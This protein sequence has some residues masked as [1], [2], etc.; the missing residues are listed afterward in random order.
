[1]PSTADLVVL[2]SL[3]RGQPRTGSLQQRLEAFYRPQAERYDRFREH[4]LHGRAELL[5]RLDLRPGQVLVELGAGTARNAEFLGAALATLARYEAVDLCPALLEQAERRAARHPVIRV[6]QADAGCYRPPGPV[7]RVLFSYALTMMPAWREALDN[8]ITMLVSG[9]LL[10]VVDFHVAHAMAPAGRVRHSAFVRAVWPR[11][12]RRDGVELDAARLDAL[13]Q[14]LQRL[15][16]AERMGAL[17]FVPLL[18]VPHYLFI[19][20]KPGPRPYA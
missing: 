7:H 3:L 8:A 19:G 15:F 14:R 5:R 11:W 12:F 1:M 18:R 10:G 17:P 13:E 16:L 2:R 20:R 6:V 4:M 9:G